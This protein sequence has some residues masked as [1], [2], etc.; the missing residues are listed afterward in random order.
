MTQL[1]MTSTTRRGTA[2]QMT[3]EN[4][5]GADEGGAGQ[6]NELFRMMEIMLQDRERREAEQI[7]ERRVE[8]QAYQMSDI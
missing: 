7:E 6:G 4:V 8:G 3:S 5:G 2:Y 1:F